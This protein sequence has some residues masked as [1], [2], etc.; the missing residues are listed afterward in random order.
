MAKLVLPLFSQLFVLYV[1]T[2]NATWTSFNYQPAFISS[3]C[4]LHSSR[5]NQI[6]SIY[7]ISKQIVNGQ[8]RRQ[9]LLQEGA[10]IEIML[11]STRGVL[12]GRVQQLL[13]D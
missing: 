7:I 6:H 1:V 4:K 13:D 9:E 10:K 5:K 11:C 8:W 2:R 3:S 12:R